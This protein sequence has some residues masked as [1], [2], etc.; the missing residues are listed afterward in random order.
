MPADEGQGP[1]SAEYL[2]Y[3]RLL[4]QADEI[5]GLRAALAQEAVKNTPDRARVERAEAELAAVKGSL[6]WRAG[7]AVLAPFWLVKRALKRSEQ[8]L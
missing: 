4:S 8:G 1:G 2:D 3:Q 5:Q 6:T 7:R